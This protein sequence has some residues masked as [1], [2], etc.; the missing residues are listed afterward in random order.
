MPKMK[1]IRHAVQ[2]YSV[3]VA[4]DYRWLW[5]EPRCINGSSKSFDPDRD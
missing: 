3:G 4:A 5:H 2:I 1:T